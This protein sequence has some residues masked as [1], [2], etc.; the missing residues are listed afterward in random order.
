MSQLT[1]GDITLFFSAY[2]VLQ[3][4]RTLTKPCKFCKNMATTYENLVKHMNLALWQMKQLKK[5]ETVIDEDQLCDLMNDQNDTLM[6]L[7]E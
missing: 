7:L 2:R 5:E 3:L 1:H 4:C 6:Q